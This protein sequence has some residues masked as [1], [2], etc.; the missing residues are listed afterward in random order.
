MTLN[1]CFRSVAELHHAPLQT[2]IPN[3]PY[4]R[5]LLEFSAN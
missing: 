3:G 5:E 2:L 4:S 1:D